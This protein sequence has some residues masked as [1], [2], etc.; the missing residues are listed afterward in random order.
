M[1]LVLDGSITLAWCFRDEATPAIDALMLSAARVGAIV[2][3]IW[4]LEVANGLRS[5]MRRRRMTESERDEILVALRDMEIETDPD[6]D[7]FAWPTTQRL[8][9]LHGLTPYDASYLEL[10]LRMKLP[11]G[12]LD[13]ALCHAARAEA[14]AVVGR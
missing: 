11:L 6:T 10:A 1:R 9:D 8:A 5:A 13:N 3:G 14:V 4:R 12:S 7:R 2:P